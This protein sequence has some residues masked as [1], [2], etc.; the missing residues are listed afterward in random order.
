MA[1]NGWG[2]YFNDSKEKKTEAGDNNNGLG[3]WSQPKEKKIEIKEN[4][5]GLGQGWTF[6]KREK[7]I[8]YNPQGTIKATK[9]TYVNEYGDNI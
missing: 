6:V 1:N 4:K 3:D 7:Q 8:E 2:D 5:H 9:T